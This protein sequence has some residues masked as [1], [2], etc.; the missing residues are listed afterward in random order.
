MDTVLKFNAPI[1]NSAVEAS[2]IENSFEVTHVEQNWLKLNDHYNFI[3]FTDFSTFF[4]YFNFS[5]NIFERYKF[6][7]VIIL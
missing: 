3:D 5:N 1:F 7:S 6:H 4:E 2:S